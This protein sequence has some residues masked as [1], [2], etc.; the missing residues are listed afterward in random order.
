MHVPLC[1]HLIKMY[2]LLPKPKGYVF[3]T[4]FAAAQAF[5]LLLLPSFGIKGA[6]VPTSHTQYIEF[7]QK[8]KH[9]LAWHVLFQDALA[10]VLGLVALAN[11]P[12]E[13]QKQFMSW[14]TK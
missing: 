10:N 9:G 7:I 14:V 12:A 11:M 8:Y 6:S 2:N 5:P 4:A 3:L 1:S 13:A